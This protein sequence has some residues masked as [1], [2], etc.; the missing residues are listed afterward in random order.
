MYYLTLINYILFNKSYLTKLM[1]DDMARKVNEIKKPSDN[2][3]EIEDYDN[4]VM[5]IKNQSVS[6]TY[7]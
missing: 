5:E 6:W 1:D 4:G 3:T 2:E 7:K